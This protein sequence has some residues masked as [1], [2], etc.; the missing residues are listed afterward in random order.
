MIY[1]DKIF[2]M[3]PLLF[4]HK[5]PLANQARRWGTK[6]CHMWSDTH[7]IEELVTFAIKLKLKPSYLKKGRFPHFDLI[8]SKRNLALKLG[9]IE[10]DLKEF[11]HENLVT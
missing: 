5:N 4:K 11:I 3:D 7:N 2:E 1:V 10:K 8:P 9:A 6:W